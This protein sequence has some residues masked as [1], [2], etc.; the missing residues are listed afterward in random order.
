LKKSVFPIVNGHLSLKAPYKT[1][2]IK[3][4]GTKQIKNRIKAKEEEISCIKKEMKQPII[5]S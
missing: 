5:L 1:L 4:Y 3:D 2:R